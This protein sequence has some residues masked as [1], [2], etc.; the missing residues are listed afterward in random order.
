M[1]ENTTIAKSLLPESEW[2]RIV[3][4]NLASDENII[5]WIMK[6][7]GGVQTNSSFTLMK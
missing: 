7:N 4:F 5:D 3:N 6:E 1:Y 2:W